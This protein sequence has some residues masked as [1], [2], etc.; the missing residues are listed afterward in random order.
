MLVKLLPS[1]FY[2]NAKLPE[3]KVTGIVGAVGQTIFTWEGRTSA[4]EEAQ[5][6]P[7]S[8]RP[9]MKI[10][11]AVCLPLAETTTGLECAPAMLSTEVCSGSLQLKQ[12]VNA[13]PI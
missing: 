3:F 8:P 5:P 9:C 4:K 6:C 1:G 13:C 12:C 10:R 2:V 11:V 7:V